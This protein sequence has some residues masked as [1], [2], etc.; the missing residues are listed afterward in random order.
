M[1]IKTISY[2]LYKPKS[3]HDYAALFKAIRSFPGHCHAMDSVWL[4]AT[5]KSCQEVYEELAPHINK[6]DFVLVNALSPYRKGLLKKS[7]W[8]WLKKHE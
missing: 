7:V 1:A 6:G 4:V 8:E 3:G 2:D 5:N